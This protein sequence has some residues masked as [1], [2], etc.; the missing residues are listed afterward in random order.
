MLPVCYLWQVS[1]CCGIV[2]RLSPKPQVGTLVNLQKIFGSTPCCNHDRFEGLLILGTCPSLGL[3]NK[4]VGNI[5]WHF[6]K[7]FHAFFFTFYC[8]HFFTFYWYAPLLPLCVCIG[9]LGWAI[10]DVYGLFSCGKLIWKLWR[11]FQHGLW[12]K[13]Q[14]LSKLKGP[15]E[16]FKMRL[17]YVCFSFWFASIHL[18]SGLNWWRCNNVVAHPDNCEDSALHQH[19][20]IM[21]KQS[22]KRRGVY[23]QQTSREQKQG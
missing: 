4:R 19:I 23:I 14:M 12:E 7:W 11:M 10:V 17:V 15:D 20:R 9:C 18:H 3:Q 13:T 1:C 8:L 16:Y 2:H 6:S 21:P 5:F 22:G